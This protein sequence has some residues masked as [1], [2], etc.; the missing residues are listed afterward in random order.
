MALIV[1]LFSTA[2]V[3]AKVE[4]ANLFKDILPQALLGSPQLGPS[5]DKTVDGCTCTGPCGATAD[6]GF[7]CDW[8]NVQ[9][10]CGKSKLFGGNWDYCVYPEEEAFEAQDHVAKMNQVWTEMTAP[11]VVGKS[12]PMKD[13][14]STVGQMVAE[15]MRTTMDNHRDVLPVGRSKVIHPQGVHCQFELNVGSDSEYTGI[16]SPGAKAGIV[17]MGSATSTE[18]SQGIF[19]GMGIKF[20]RSNVHSANFVALR[21]TGPGGSNNYFEGDLTNHVSPPSALRALMKFQQA[22]NCISMVGLSDV[23]TYDQDGSQASRANFPYE[24]A[25]RSTSEF[26]LPNEKTLKNEKLLHD[27][28]S[29][30]V[31][32]TIFDVY[33]TSSPKATAKKLGSMKTNGKC[34]QSIFGDTKLAF[35]HQRM[36][37]DFNLRPEWIPD[38]NFGACEATAA[39]VSKWQCPFVH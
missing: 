36:E 29:I 9:D 39:P 18:G 12:G 34:V 17:R 15:S 2:Q 33:A 8:C 28:S 37:A 30:P 25:F 5:R 31:G 26:Q 7:A 4:F 38:V 11:D 10:G 20:F 1:Y 32:T 6:D 22:S 16:F 23:C 21:S 24:I 14:F 3:S 19:P 35:K 13:P 27:L